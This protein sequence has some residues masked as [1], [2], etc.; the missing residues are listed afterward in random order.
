[1]SNNQSVISG[2]ASRQAA[3]QLLVAVLKRKQ[4]LDQAM[5]DLPELLA[6]DRGFAYH[7]AKTALRYHLGL[8]QVVAQYLKKPLAA[9][10]EEIQL[11]LHLAAVQILLLD[12]PDY[13]AVNS[14]V[15]LAKQKAKPLAGLVNAVSKKLI[16]DKAKILASQHVTG[17]ACTPA[18]L[19]KSWEKV[20]GPEKAAAIATVHLQEP[21]LDVNWSDAIEGAVS[22]EANIQRL[23]KGTYFSDLAG[24]GWAQDAAAAL[25]VHLLGEVSG[26]RVLDACA[27]PG[28]KTMQLARAGAKVTALDI[29]Q[30]R[31]KRLHENLQRNQLQAE[32]VC[33]DL[34]EWEPSEAFDI[35][36][37][38]A[39]CSATGT[40]RRHP[41][42]LYHRS[43]ADVARLVAIQAELLEQSLQWVK[44]GGTLLYITCSLQPEEGEG[45]LATYADQI[46]PFPKG[47][48]ISPAGMLRTT[49][50]DLPEHGHRDGFFAAQI[51]A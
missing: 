26:K 40:I 32:V 42:I 43:E 25:P 20:Y 50:A 38:D 9:K 33:A 51:G 11:C 12:T 21:P 45:Q 28:G 22:L 34:R 7:L 35:V 4:T 29:S 31:L 37:L 8:K 23:P 41:E 13:A 18:W 44:P 19:W 6:S 39:P 49:P 14:S 30:N 48:N 15:E 16:A 10:H 5:M 36:V 47:P 2:L 17:Q 46:I 1:M 3:L 27:A 24:T